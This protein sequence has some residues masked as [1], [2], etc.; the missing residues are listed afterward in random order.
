M[1]EEVQRRLSSACRLLTGSGSG[2]KN[3]RMCRTQW[4]YGPQHNAEERKKAI[5]RTIR[6]NKDGQ[7]GRWADFRSRI[8]AV[9]VAR[10]AM[11]YT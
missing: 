2:V 5:S 7:M 8:A 9:A 1:E 4:K 10:V 6:Q 3:I 11:G